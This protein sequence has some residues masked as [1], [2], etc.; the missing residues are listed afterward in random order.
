MGSDYTLRSKRSSR[1]LRCRTAVYGVV[2]PIAIVILIVSLFQNHT[3][4]PSTV[5]QLSSGLTDPHDAYS[6]YS[7]NSIQQTSGSHPAPC[8]PCTQSTAAGNQHTP[9]NISTHSSGARANDTGLAAQALN[10]TGEALPSLFL[11][12]G[13][14]SGRGYRHRRLAVREAWANKAQIPGV[15]VA[16]FILSEDER[17]AHAAQ[18]LAIQGPGIQL[19]VQY[20]HA[21]CKGG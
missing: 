3:Q 21:G 13:V 17:P 8:P 14:L 6:S 16:R 20:K 10:S 11:F 9:L 1:P 5:R 2:A 7:I 12:T 15:P 4:L 19:M 18:T